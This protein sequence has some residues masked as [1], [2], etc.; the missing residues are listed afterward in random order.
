[1]A[2]EGYWSVCRNVVLCRVVLRGTQT[3]ARPH[4]R[5]V[6]FKLCEEHTAGFTY[7]LLICQPNCS[8]SRE[9]GDLQWA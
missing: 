6:E 1:M 4:S 9:L 3:P 7:L 5:T 2:V 8:S